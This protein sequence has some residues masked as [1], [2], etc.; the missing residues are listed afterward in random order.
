MSGQAR[1]E[2]LEVFTRLRV[3]LLKFAQAADLALSNAESDISR[4]HSWLETEQATYW[5]GQLRKRTEA[6]TRAREAVRQ[7]KL[8]KDATGRTPSAIEE[9][10]ALARAVAA[11][12][13]AEWK[14]QAIKKALP[15]LEKE[16]DLYRGGVAPLSRNLA[17]EI[18]RAVALLDRLSASLQEY[19][20]LESPSM[21]LRE[22]EAPSAPDAQLPSSMTLP[23]PDSFAPEEPH[24]AR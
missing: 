19:L 24:D 15:R 4:A 12:E 9:E 16:A 21:T 7:K 13:Q 6:V 5:T 18:P 17:G 23:T 14:I 8:F 10:K 22:T 2:D 1:V 11:V 20:A 3:A